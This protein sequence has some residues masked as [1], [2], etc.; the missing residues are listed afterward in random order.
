MSYNTLNDH[1]LLGD[2][3]LGSFTGRSL[4]FSASSGRTTILYYSARWYDYS[5]TDLSRV[6]E[7]VRSEQLGFS[8]PIKNLVELQYTKT[9]WVVHGTDSSIGAAGGYIVVKPNRAWRFEVAGET[10]FGEPPEQYY[11]TGRWNTPDSFPIF[12]QFMAGYYMHYNTDSPEHF[13]E[14]QVMLGTTIPIWK[15]HLGLGLS[16]R[17]DA[18]PLLPDNRA[19][20]ISLSLPADATASLLTPAFWASFHY[21]PKS[22]R[23]MLFGSFGP[24]E[25]GYWAL[26]G[27]RFSGQQILGIPTRIVS[28]RTYYISFRNLSQE[29]WARIGWA[30]N[31]F[32]FDIN[33]YTTVRSYEASLSY[34]PQSWSHGK[35]GKPS[36]QYTYA[37]HQDVTY[38][39][40]AH[41]LEHPEYVKH[42]VDINGRIRLYGN[43]EN[44]REGCLRLS[45]SSIFSKH[46]SPGFS[47]GAT[48]FI[49]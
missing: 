34:A 27:M 2:N 47:V 10:F 3:N 25:L 16:S 20:T 33:D 32:E 41:R 1:R 26:Y 37:S 48:L 38:N 39:P 13:F 45:V 8:V 49:L 18:S 35:L 7:N 23:L 22:R 17:T 28:N 4:N 11:F 15:M 44:F 12:S 40:M 43:D 21:K 9:D 46:S 6:D 30:L 36:C 24:G 42:I 5:S 19:W 29:E 31:L 14:E